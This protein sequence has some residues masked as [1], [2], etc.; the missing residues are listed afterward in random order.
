MRNSLWVTKQNTD[1]T[2]TDL[3]QLPPLL[4]RLWL[5]KQRLW[6]RLSTTCPSVRQD[7][8]RERYQRVCRW[9]H[10]RVWVGVWHALGRSRLL[11]G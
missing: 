3:Q 8:E 10:V 9:V 7:V 4:L 11:L 5:W 2:D 6:A 1:K